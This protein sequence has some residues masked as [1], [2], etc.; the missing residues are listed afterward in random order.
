MTV[1]QSRADIRSITR[2]TPWKCGIFNFGKAVKKDVDYFNCGLVER[3][4]G[5]WLIVRRA[6]FSQRDKLGYNDIVAFKLNGLVPQFG[7]PVQMGK[8]FSIEHFEDPRAYYHE[9]RTFIS[10][11][12]FI[13]NG[14]GC[15]FPH[16]VIC[17]VND[18]W[19]LVKR[20]DPV[21]GH[22]G[23]DQSSNALHEKNW[24]W[25]FHEGKMALCYSPDP[26][27]VAIL[28]K[29]FKYW[30]D[31]STPDNTGTC[32]RYWTL[33]EDFT[34]WQY[35]QMRGG[36]PPILHNGEYWTF[37]HSS[38]DIPVYRRQYHMGAYAFE[39]KP[40]FRITK[41]TIEP[42]LSGSRFDR[43]ST[44]KVQCV[45][46]CG[47]LIDGDDFLVSFGL[48]DIECGWIKIPISELADQMLSL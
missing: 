41:I 5:R 17:E 10:A 34:V 18:N 20:H 26:H 40:P 23:K 46:P 43:I 6:I 14:K 32:R 47:S 3:P 48:N 31:L 1:T 4:D 19:E 9:G 13:R 42:L 24:V 16:Q 36:T 35:G 33:F 21:Y 45:F 30:T 44:G 27:E 38:T 2:Q 22:N 12:N 28:D 29:D 39:A 7:I 15:T 25:F 8:M 37:F 11:C